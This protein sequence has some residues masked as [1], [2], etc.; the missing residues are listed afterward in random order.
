MI[1]IGLLTI[2]VLRIPVRAFPRVESLVVP[3]FRH[4]LRG[5]AGHTVFLAGVANGFLPCGLVYAFLAMSLAAA[6]PVLGAM[7]MLAFGAGTV[8]AMT[9]LGCG[10]GFVAQRSRARIR[11]NAAVVVV[12]A[13]AVTVYR[14]IPSMNSCCDPV[15]QISFGH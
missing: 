13:G 1:V 6:N 12:M 14:A 5:T 8:P 11:Q 10:G 4:F 9:L 7:L 3:A 15:S 2:G